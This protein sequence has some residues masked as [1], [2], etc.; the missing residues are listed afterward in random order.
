MISYKRTYLLVSLY[1]CLQACTA[2]QNNLESS[3]NRL[4]ILDKEISQNPQN[5]SLYLKR[6]YILDSTKNYLKALSDVNEVL[7]M[8]NKNIDAYYLRGLLKIKLDDA[9]GAINDF[10]KII[11]LDPK[12]ANAYFQRALIRLQVKDK[13]GACLELKKALE[14]K[15]PKA[16]EVI[17][18][19]CK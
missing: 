4:I 10:N 12:N 5:S 3:H 15:H 13:S 17:T 1:F 6:A 8:N 14:Y 16:Q 19:N 9:S 18:Q 7:K 11:L 2:Q